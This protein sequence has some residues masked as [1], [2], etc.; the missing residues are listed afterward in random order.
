VYQ[1]EGKHDEALREINEALR[2][3]PERGF[4][5]FVLSQINGRR[6]AASL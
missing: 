1:A 4:S 5:K 6:Q 3:D 2:L